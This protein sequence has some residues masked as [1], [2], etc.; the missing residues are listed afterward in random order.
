MEETAIWK[1]RRFRIYDWLTIAYIA[2]WLFLI[3]WNQSRIPYLSV[4]IGIHLLSILMSFGLAGLSPQTAF[5]KFLQ[6][7]YPVFFLPLFFTGLHYLVPAIHPVDFDPQLIRA[8]YWLTGGY[9]TVWLEKFY[10]PLLSDFLQ[11]CY[12]TFYFLPLLILIPLQIQKRSVHFERAAS[13]FLLTFYL[14]YLGYLVFPALGPRFYLAHL[15]HRMIPGGFIFHY[16]NNVLNGL[17]SV[18]WDAFPS[19][20]VA[21]A[22]VY[23]Y[24]AYIYFRKLFY[25]TLLFVI[26]LIFS[27]L[28][29]RYHYLID[30]I[31]GAVLFLL[32]ALIDHFFLI[33]RI[34]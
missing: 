9:P 34:K 23:A 7:W 15:H 14:S 1:I 29:L 24:F 13:V 31:A 17:E 2:F 4:F 6:R 25:W 11:L 3:I 22:L 5:L 21:I 30:L 33:K 32:V 19:G 26:A 18:Q 27:T 10:H 20:H 16:L 8:D 12:S 28:Y